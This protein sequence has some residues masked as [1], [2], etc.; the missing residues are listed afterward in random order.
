[1]KRVYESLRNNHYLNLVVVNLRYL[2]GFGFIPSGFIKI[3]NDPFTRP[4][5]V[6]VFFDYLDALYTTGYYYNMIGFMQVFAAVLLITQRF[7]TLGAF[8]FLPIIFNISVLTLSTIGSL[9]PVL[10]TL[11]LLGIIFLLL[12]D[13]YKW[14]N[15]FK[16]DNFKQELQE[17]NEYPTYTSTHAITGIFLL[18]IPFT[19]Y[20][21]SFYSLI[22]PSLII[23]FLLGN[24]YSEWNYRRKNLSAK[25]SLI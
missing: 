20:L 1:M 4:E 22:I 9:T 6:G 7:A 18:L 12:W 13:Y 23:I 11:M 19:F 25:K 16:P 8:I 24:C 2:I 15:I 21:L 10:A 17:R 14:I 5:N 3:I